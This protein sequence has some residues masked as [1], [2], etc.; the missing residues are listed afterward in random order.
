M[1]K[2]CR[3]I[4]CCRGNLAQRVWT[5]GKLT[6]YTDLSHFDLDVEVVATLFSYSSLD[7]SLTSDVCILS[8]LGRVVASGLVAPLIAAH[9]GSAV[10]ARNRRPAKR[11]E[12]DNS[13]EGVLE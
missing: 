8:K 11:S 6:S 7:R 2:G 9:I 13:L 3:G 5:L 12:S 1:Y 10:M 4:A